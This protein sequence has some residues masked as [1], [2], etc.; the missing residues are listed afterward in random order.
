MTQRVVLTQH[1]PAPRAT[2]YAYWTNAERLATWWWPQLP[3]TTYEVDA[4]V[5]GSYRIRSDGAGFGAHG[6]FT[7]LDEPRRIAMTWVWETGD[8]LSPEDTV[9]VDFAEDDGGTLVTVTHAVVAA[10]EDTSGLR[11]GW[12]DVLTRLGE[13]R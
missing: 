10:D 1:V 4:R 9:V 7:E 11:R 8:V 5:G 6:R 13:L 12:S 2:V 3:D